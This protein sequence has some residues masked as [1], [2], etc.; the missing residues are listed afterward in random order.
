MEKRSARVSHLMPCSVVL[1]TAGTAEQT[2][3]MTATCVF[4]SEEPPLLVVSVDKHS[5]THDLIEETSEFV[6]NIASSDQVKLAR[7]LGAAHGKKVDKLK[8]FGIGTEK[9]AKVKA[10]IIKGSFAGI[11]CKVI[12]SFPVSH[13]TVYVA[14]AVNSKVSGKTAPV[15]W[16]RDRYFKLTEEV[17]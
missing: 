9:A 5:L 6:L 11:E 17:R 14:E 12:T 7:K 8:A 1:L 3:A 13:Y 10:P 2:D 4:I 16:H 15:A